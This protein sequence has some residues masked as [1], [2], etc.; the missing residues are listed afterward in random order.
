MPAKGA[1]KVENGPFWDQKWAN[2][3]G[4][5]GMHIW[6]RA[7]APSCIALVNLRGHSVTARQRTRM[8][9]ERLRGKEDEEVWAGHVQGARSPREPWVLLTNH[10][11]LKASV[12]EGGY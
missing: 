3:E 4:S 9:D 12:Q 10:P 7:L 8:R 6:I 11:Y 2:C 1:K 5:K